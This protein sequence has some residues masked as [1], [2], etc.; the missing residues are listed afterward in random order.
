MSDGRGRSADEREAARLER[1]TA[2]RE[3][4]GKPVRRGEGGSPPARVTRV[5]RPPAARIASEDRPDALPRDGAG[6]P[7][8][9]RHENGAPESHE[10]GAPESHES[11]GHEVHEAGEPVG[12]ATDEHERY[13]TGEHEL[14]QA[15]GTRRI[16]HGDSLVVRR[17]GT[18]KRAKVDRAKVDRAKVDRAKRSK[19][20][21]PRSM[22][23]LWIG[24]IT[25]LIALVLAGALIWFVVQLFQ[26]LQG[27]PHG[28]ITI[29]IPPRSTSSQ[30]GQLLQRGGVISSSFFFELRATLAGER[31]DLR[32]GTYHLQ[33]GMTYGAVLTALTTPPHAAKVT[34]L[35]ITEGQRRQQIGALLRAQHV[36]GSYVAATR[37]SKL[38]NPRAYGLRHAPPSLEGFLFPDTYQLTDPVQIPVLVDDQ[39]RAF[40]REFARVSRG[41]TQR[42]H[43]TPYDVLIIASLIEAETPTA[44]DRPLVS[45]VIYNRLAVGMTLGLDSTT[46]YA[47]GNFTRPLT[48]S[49]LRS[50]SPYNTRTHVG[51]PP[52]PIG[53]PGLASMQA[54]A[55]P[56]RTNYLYF[57]AKPCT[58]DTVFANNY[59]QFLGLLQRDRRPHCH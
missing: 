53:N 51:L 49:Q 22:R 13:E 14:E 35:T 38:L 6:V 3:R 5:I 10:N 55:H 12:Y 33:L 29:T 16:S 34:N 37:S 21:R 18:P 48:V 39:L 17:R 2:R 52:T 40:K 4:E 26:P 20:T 57:F 8:A 43:L 32:A 28:R 19:S 7:P 58:N 41:Y 24:R 1:E 27:S 56:A 46:Q 50:S 54:A 9:L 15:S 44:H 25:S 36:R 59:A 23:R 30:V 47:T 31:S 42:K 11:E 45:S